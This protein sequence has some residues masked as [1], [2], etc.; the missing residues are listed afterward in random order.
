[1]SAPH[2]LREEQSG[3]EPHRRSDGMA[4]LA[5]TGV[6]TGAVLLL[7]WMRRRMRRG[8]RRA[9]RPLP[10][11]AIETR[12]IEAALP[13]ACEP[14]AVET[15]ETC[16]AVAHVRIAVYVGSDYDS[17]R[18]LGPHSMTYYRKW[19]PLQHRENYIITYECMACHRKRV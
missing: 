17:E 19:K 8:G 10:P 4:A 2:A 7:W 3:A 13:E 5:L 11:L 16:G 6:A 1:M 12:D 18:A 14:V 15:C 9:K